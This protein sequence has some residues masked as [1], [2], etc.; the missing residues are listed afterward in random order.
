MLRPGLAGAEGGCPQKQKP[1][2]LCDR[3]FI[4]FW[5]RVPGLSS[6]LLGL[7]LT[8]YLAAPPRVNCLGSVGCSPVVLGCQFR[9]ASHGGCSARGDHMGSIGGRPVY[10]CQFCFALTAWTRRT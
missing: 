4:L 10:G 8:S 6:D 1:D 5:L 3:G 2:R 9:F 7:R